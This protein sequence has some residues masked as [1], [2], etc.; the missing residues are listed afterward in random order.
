MSTIDASCGAGSLQGIGTDNKDKT[1]NLSQGV[2]AE[3]KQRRA[4]YSELANKKGCIFL[5]ITLNMAPMPV[6]QAQGELQIKINR[7]NSSLT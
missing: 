2:N 5:G 7:Q 6:E 1:K 3:A 4:A